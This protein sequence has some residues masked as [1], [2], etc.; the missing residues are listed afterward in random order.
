MKIQ[1]TNEQKQKLITDWYDA[2]QNLDQYK[3]LEKNLR[4]QVIEHVFEGCEP[5]TNRVDLANGFKLKTVIKETYKVPR[6]ATGHYTHVPTLL[7]K[8]PDDVA[9]SIIKW[10][11]DISTSA[12]KTLTEEQKAVVNEFII[13]TKGSSTLEI[14]EPKP[15]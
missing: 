9:R 4:E 1:L 7:A 11:L 12:Y 13:I 15:Q 14:E 3:E 8:L 5:G 6:D 10:T 2:K